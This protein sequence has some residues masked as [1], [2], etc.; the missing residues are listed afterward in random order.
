M[1]QG[2]RLPASSFK[3]TL[4]NSMIE[5]G[6]VTKI[7]QGKTKAELF[8]Q[9]VEALFNY[10]RN[11]YAIN[12]LAAYVEQYEL[13]QARSESVMLSGNSKLKNTR[14]FTGF[15]VNTYTPVTAILNGHTFVITPQV[16]SSLFIHD[17]TGFQIPADITVVG[18]ENPENF[19]CIHK[20]Q[21]LF[22]R[23]QPL[24]VSRYPQSGDLVQW[25]LSIDNKYLHF[26]DLDFAGINIFANEYYQHLGNRAS[27][28]IPPRVQEL[29][30]RFG[31]R[32]LY[33]QQLLKAKDPMISSG[34]TQ[35]I[36]LIHQHRKGLEQE[37][38][39]NAN[40]AGR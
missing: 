30:P 7:Q 16:G 37:I 22:D 34:I 11:L 1:V 19:R 13:V 20:Q 10:L 5:D 32:D 33:N 35:L 31:N 4:A 28:F 24:F 3:H 25:L 2:H 21:Y 39:I 26:G 9:D 18:I 40:V 14:T 12:D 6:V 17:F 8:V 27:F 38:F 29:L 36:S 23:I 15:P